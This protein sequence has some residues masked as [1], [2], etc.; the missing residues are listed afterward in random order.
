M[1][2]DDFIR[3]NKRKDFRM[4]HQ[5]YTKFIYTTAW[6]LKLTGRLRNSADRGILNEQ[7][8]WPFWWK[9]GYFQTR[10]NDF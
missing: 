9:G 8:V 5:F 3:L 1:F 2:G 6:P 10:L 4:G 7:N